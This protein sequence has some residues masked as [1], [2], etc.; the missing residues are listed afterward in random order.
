LKHYTLLHV[1]QQIGDIFQ[2]GVDDLALTK[3]CV[4]VGQKLLLLEQP[5]AIFF[6]TIVPVQV[7]LPTILLAL[8][9]SRK[10]DR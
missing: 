8:D 6:A 4:L 10:L 2:L 1:S 9:M 3:A 5:H 7:V